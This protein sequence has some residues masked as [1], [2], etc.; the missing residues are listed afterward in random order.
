M[1]DDPEVQSQVQQSPEPEP[2]TPPSAT[3]VAA[4]QSQGPAP[5]VHF[6]S[7]HVGAN[8]FQIHQ[9]I[10]TTDHPIGKILTPQESAV[11]IEWLKSV[12]NTEL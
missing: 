7:K 11:V 4:G 6:H 8:Q 10:G 9:R 3:D 12:E 2:P 1:Q 5:H